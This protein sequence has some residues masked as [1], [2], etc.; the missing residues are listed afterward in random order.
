MNHQSKFPFREH[1]E[2]NYGNKKPEYIVPLEIQF[3]LRRAE[4]TAQGMTKKQLFSALMKLYYQRLMEWQAFK[5]LI[6]ESKDFEFSIPTDLDLKKLAEDL[7][8][9]EGDE[10]VEPPF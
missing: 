9:E 1:Q 6:G 8:Q 10:N 2:D 5:D 4:I 7:S 3:S